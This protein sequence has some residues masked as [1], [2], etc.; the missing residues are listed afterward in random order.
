[1]P[2]GAVPDADAE[3]DAD[4]DPDPEPDPDPDPDDPTRRPLASG[5]EVAHL[6]TV[7]VA[8][9]DGGESV[10]TSAEGDGGEGDGG[11]ACGRLLGSG[12]LSS[13]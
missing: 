9:G 12:V 6:G 2:S 13:R 4:A 8:A 1:M 5:A 3:A 7:V 10:R 11:C